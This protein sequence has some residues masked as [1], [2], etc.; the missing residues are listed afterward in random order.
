[1]GLSVSQLRAIAQQRDRYQTQLNRL[2]ALGKQTSCIEA[3]VSSAC[4]TL[5]SGT[6]SFVIYGEPQSGKTE[7]MICLTAKMLDDGHRVVVHLLND[8]V[9][10]LQQNLD[11]FQRSKLSPAARNF[12]DVIDPEYSLSAGYHVIFCKKNAS[13]L[14]KLNQKLERITDKVIIDDE[15]DF[16]TP[17]ALINKGDVTKINALI[18]K[19]ISHDG[20]YIGVTATPAR[21]DLNNTFDND[22][23]KWVNFPPHEAYTGQDVFFPLDTDVQFS[24]HTLPDTDDSPKYLREAIFR[25]LVRVAALNLATKADEN[26][27]M[28]IHTSG[29]KLDHK[30]DKRPIDDVMNTLSDTHSKKFE[31]YTHEIG[32][33][34]TKLYG[35]EQASSILAYIVTNCDQTST[36]IM[37]SERDKNVDFKSATSPAAMFTF[38][39]GGNIVSRGVT[40][41]NLLSMFFTRDSKHKIQQDTYIQRARM[42]GS[43][44]KHLPYFELT[45]PEPLYLDWQRCFAFHKLALEAIKT[46]KGSPV[47]LADQRI[48]AVASSSIDKANVVLDKGEMT[49]PIFDY[50]SDIE[51][52]LHGSNDPISS[53]RRLQEK[54]GNDALPDYLIRYVQRILP[55]GPTS[56]ALH[57]SSTIENMKDADK[58]KIER[59]KGLFGQAKR[60]S[61][62]ALHHFKIFYNSKNKAR[63]I[64]RFNGNI[65]FLKNVKN[66]G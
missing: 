58:D 4:D 64:Y 53:L 12:S 30:S 48:A 36:V 46:K 60:E 29:K 28:L 3:A 43:R 11:R 34:A 37:N 47:W 1:M 52:F 55:N 62:D 22:N 15:A 57:P 32:K 5:E 63:L 21:L 59:R 14:T 27:S 41:D 24:L 17:N 26:F 66:V 51:R 39:I 7:M 31:S 61:P 18:K 25:F 10:L 54:I 50:S 8:S 49:F 42:F 40:F 44:K 13:D 45:I 33:I 20:I 23:E 65:T 6:T 38:V 16:A 56:I 9:Q 2:K 35:P 19:L